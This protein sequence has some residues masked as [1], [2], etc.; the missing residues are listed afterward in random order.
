M[1]DNRVMAVGRSLTQRPGGRSL[2]QAP[3]PRWPSLSRTW[4]SRPGSRSCLA[5]DPQ[6]GVGARGGGARRLARRRIPAGRALVGDAGDRLALYRAGGKAT[7][8]S[9]SS[10]PAAATG[11][12]PGG[13]VPGP[14]AIL[15][16]VSRSQDK[17]TSAGHMRAAILVPGSAAAGPIHN[18]VRRAGIWGVSRPPRRQSRSPV[19]VPGLCCWPLRFAG[20]RPGGGRR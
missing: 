8:C 5:A 12:P 17:P 19:A 4:N 3:C 6:G 20:R 18:L 10:A 16:T 9:P 13:D 2:L 1:A 14:A 11:Q 7:R 15:S